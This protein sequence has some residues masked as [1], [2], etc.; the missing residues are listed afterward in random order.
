MSLCI[1]GREF[2][3]SLFPTLATLLLLP[4]LLGL[5]LWQW[6]RAEQKQALQDAFQSRVRQEAVA[7][8]TLATPADELYRTVTAEGRYDSAHQIL[9][10]NQ[11][12]QGQPGYYVYTPLRLTDQ[13]SAV[14]VN[15]GWVPLGESRA[16]QPV[17]SLNEADIRV[18][19]RLGQ[20]SNPGILLDNPRTNQWPKVVQHIDYSELSQALEYTLTDAV[21]LLDPAAPDGYVRNWQPTFGGMG[22]ERHIGYAVQWFALAI[23]LIIIYIVMNFKRSSTPKL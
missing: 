7:L 15:R 17:V 20:P 14:L 1:A 11:V 2:R 8:Q 19:G 18:T 21:I 23:T 16:Q 4:L 6:Q 3:P 10:D 22:P 13:Q 9:L 5:S 12:Y